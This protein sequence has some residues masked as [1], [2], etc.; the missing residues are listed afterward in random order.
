MCQLSI[1][2]PCFAVR[3][4]LEALRLCNVHVLQFNIAAAC[5]NHES[6]KTSAAVGRAAGSRT[7][8][9]LKSIIKA[10]VSA[11]STQFGRS[12]SRHDAHHTS[13]PL[14]EISGASDRLAYQFCHPGGRELAMAA[15]RPGRPVMPMP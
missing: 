11:S 7:R 4:M 5:R 6:C 15:I 2:T 1:Q 3:S 12:A 13:A 8:I 9:F 14:G 10:S